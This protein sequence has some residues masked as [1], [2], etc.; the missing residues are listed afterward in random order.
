MKRYLLKRRK[1][2][3]LFILMLAFSVKDV[4]GKVSLPEI[5]SDNMVLQQKQAVS[6]WGRGPAS[7][8]V[9]VTTS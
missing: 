1:A 6:L 5:F 7:G 8:N 9:R 2:G 3:F 4:A